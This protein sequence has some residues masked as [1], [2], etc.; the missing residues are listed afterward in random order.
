MNGRV[1]NRK[2]RPKKYRSTSLAGGELCRTARLQGASI[3]GIRVHMS[4][5]ISEGDHG[6]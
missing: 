4:L 6:L 2:P 5:L 1:F 3:H